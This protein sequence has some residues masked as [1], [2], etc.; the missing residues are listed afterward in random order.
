MHLLTEE[1]PE[2]PTNRGRTPAGA[3]KHREVLMA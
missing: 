1:S 3:K 2:L